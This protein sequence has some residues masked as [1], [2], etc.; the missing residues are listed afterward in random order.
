MTSDLPV[1]LFKVFCWKSIKMTTTSVDDKT[2]Y[3][4]NQTN[5]VVRGQTV[6]IL[7]VFFSLA[8]QNYLVFFF[9]FY[10][11]SFFQ[12]VGDD[13][14]TETIA[15]P[16][17]LHVSDTTTRFGALHTTFSAEAV[18]V[19]QILTTN[20][21]GGSHFYNCVCIKI[22]VCVPLQHWITVCNLLQGVMENHKVEGNVIRKHINL[23]I[24]YTCL[25][26]AFHL[27]FY[28]IFVW[29][30]LFSIRLQSQITSS[31]PNSLLVA[32]FGDH[33]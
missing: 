12:D 13:W 1:Y 16:N 9:N 17:S 26:L 28:L 4:T 10:A 3:A 24:N 31:S 8:F 18:A 7:H 6:P 20:D 23:G 32:L 11:G 25:D 22:T 29:D 2:R 21:S 33:R 5:P 30:L 19:F 14:I 27:H 15:A